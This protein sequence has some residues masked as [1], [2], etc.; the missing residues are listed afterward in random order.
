MQLQQLRD[1]TWDVRGASSPT[2]LKLAAGTSKDVA[3]SLHY[4]A[5]PTSHRQLSGAVT[6]GSVGDE[7][8]RLQQLVVEVASTSLAATPVLLPAS[9]SISTHASV[10]AVT[11]AAGSSPGGSGMLL[12]MA[13]VPVGDSLRCSFAGPL[14]DAF[15]GAVTLTARLVQHDGTHD[16]SQPVSFDISQQPQELASAGRCAIVSDAFAGGR[17]RLLPRRSSRAAAAAAPTRICN[18]QTVSFVST[19]G[20]V[21]TE[22]CGK[23]LTVSGCALPRQLCMRP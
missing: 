10:S 5:Q 15:A 20:P 9:C 19:V 2:A 1:V 18:S 12:P 13:V 17:S 6:V 21:G 8:L 11:A 16:A 7:E 14:P 22:A 4:K 3:F 23:A